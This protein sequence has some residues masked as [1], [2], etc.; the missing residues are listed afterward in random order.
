MQPFKTA[1]IVA[2]LALTATAASA[3]T[4]LINGGDASSSWSRNGYEAN[5]SAVQEQTRHRATTR[6]HVRTPAPRT[7]AGQN[8]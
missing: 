7:G 4:G 1:L 5:A 6:H 8:D 2:I 3:Q